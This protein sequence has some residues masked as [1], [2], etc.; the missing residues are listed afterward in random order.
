MKTIWNLPVTYKRGPGPM[1]C[2]T[3]DNEISGNQPVR[4]YTS[5]ITV[6]QSHADSGWMLG[7]S[8]EEM[9]ITLMYS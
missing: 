3:N 5:K 8:E 9:K 7:R 4:I 2:V 1:E 6:G